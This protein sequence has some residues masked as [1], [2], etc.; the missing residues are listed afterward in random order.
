[1]EREIF[2]RL[3]WS[4]IKG[5]DKRCLPVACHSILF[6]FIYLYWILSFFSTVLLSFFV[7]AVLLLSVFSS[8]LI[9]LPPSCLYVSL[10]VFLSL[11]QSFYLSVYLFLCLSFCLSVFIFRCFF[12]ATIFGTTFNPYH[13][14]AKSK[15]SLNSIH[16]NE[17][18]EN[19][20]NHKVNYHYYFISANA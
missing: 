10:S 12:Q 3:R 13:S 15:M 16:T 18:T 6:F 1:M 7:S 9:L 11:C 4:A 8:V 5:A 17:N 19:W 14:I 2:F 20:N